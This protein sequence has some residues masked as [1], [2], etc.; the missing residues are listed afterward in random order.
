MED[1]HSYDVKISRL[2]EEN[3][4][5]DAVLDS[6]QKLMLEDTGVYDHIVQ[7][8]DAMFRLQQSMRGCEIAEFAYSGLD[9]ITNATSTDDSFLRRDDD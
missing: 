7:V 2:E 3:W 5:F 9:D 6:I 1:T 4:R 8:R